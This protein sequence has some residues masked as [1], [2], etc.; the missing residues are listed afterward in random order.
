MRVLYLLLILCIMRTASFVTPPMPPAVSVTL[1]AS[2]DDSLSSP[3]SLEVYNIARSH[4]QLR[5]NHDHLLSQVESLRRDVIKAQTLID[6]ITGALLYADDTAFLER[7]AV[8]DPLH[9][10]LLNGNVSCYRPPVLLRPALTRIAMN[11][12]RIPTPLMHSWQSPLP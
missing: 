10:V 4:V 8:Q 3:S 11:H 9:I 5:Q 7:Q 12:C 6:D 2:H 1:A